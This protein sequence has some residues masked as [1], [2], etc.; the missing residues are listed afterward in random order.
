MTAAAAIFLSGNNYANIDR[1]AKVLSLKL[2]CQT[3]FNRIQRTCLVP[4]VD[5]FWKEHQLELCASFEGET[6]V[7]LGIIEA[8][9]KR[10]AH[11]LR[12]Q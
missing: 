9:I 1:F 2:L 8:T 11:G 10:A 7:L 12:K 5:K 3:T 6:L 4:C